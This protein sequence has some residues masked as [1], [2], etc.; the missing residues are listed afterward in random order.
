MATA[1]TELQRQ[2]ALATQTHPAALINRQRAILSLQKH[3]PS[4]SSWDVK[5]ER[6][7]AIEADIAAFFAETSK[8]KSK[9]DLE[10]DALAQLSFQGTWTKPLNTIPFMIAAIAIF[11][12]WVVPAMTVATPL[13][14]WILPYILLK[15]VWSLPIN[16]DQYM[17]LMR[18]LWSGNFGGPLP[19]PGEPLPSLWTPK[20]IAQAALFGFSFIQ[21]MVQPIQNAVHLYK[22]DK[23]FLDLGSKLVELRKM[24]ADIRT[25]A[26]AFLS[27]Q[28]AKLSYALEELTDWDIRRTFLTI[29]EQPERLHQVLKDLAKLEILWRLAQKGGSELCP[30][31]FKRGGLTL[32]NC[33]DISLS[34]AAAVPATVEFGAQPHT[35][36]TGPNGGG[37]SSFLR[38]V[39]Q[40]VLLGH[41]YG[42]APAGKAQMPRF[43]WI[44]SGLQLRDTPGVLSMFETEVKFAADVLT[45]ARRGGPGLLLYDEL[46][47]STNPPD[48]ERTAVEF[49][50]QLW[51]L[52]TVQSI[53]STHLFSLVEGAPEGRVKALCCP[54]TEKGDGRVDFTFRVEPGICRVSSVQMVWRRFGLGVDGAA[55]RP[56]APDQN[57]RAKENTGSE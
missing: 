51:E 42:V 6:A 19:M 45:R 27:P 21:G 16:T 41:T 53:V 37:K 23:V 39:L 46:F 36:L 28:Q 18:T 56:A 57:L 10:E 4:L 48:G 29:V 26:Y 50:R 17:G 2:L 25:E 43:R 35:V 24:V 15:F 22:T 38:A 20:S 44:A 12:V 32:R 55:V 3:A 34:A 31:I 47:H 11:K 5:F 52:N 14:A 8:G 54:A 13:V 1:P 33:R 40:A 7:A 49:L 30:V 9:D